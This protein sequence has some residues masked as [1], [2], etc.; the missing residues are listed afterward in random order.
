MPQGC[1]FGHKGPAAFTTQ[2]SIWLGLMQSRV[3]AAMLGLQLSAADAAARS[4]EVGI[5]QKTPVPDLRG[6]DADP[7][8]ELARDCVDIKRNLDTANETSHVF[9]RPALLA[10]SGKTLEERAEAWEAKVEEAEARLAANQREID[11]IAFRLYG[12]KGD[13][14]RAIEESL[15]LTPTDVASDA[16]TQE[17]E[18]GGDDE[19]EEG[20]EETRRDRRTLAAELISYAV[21]CAFGRFDI[22]LGAGLRTPDPLPD[23]FAPLPVC[24]PGMLTGPDG[25]P[26]APPAGYPPLAD[27]DG[28]LVEDADE[29]GLAYHQDDIVLRVR[30]ALIVLFG[31]TA[32]RIEVEA[33]RWLEI[34]SL[35]DYFKR[36]GAGGFWLDHVKRYSKSR[37]KAP[38]YWLLQSSRK[39]Y[40]LWLY[41]HKLDG[42][43][44]FKALLNYAEPA[45]KREHDAQSALRAQIET[46]PIGSKERREAERALERQEATVGEMTD[47]CEKLREAAERRL[48]PDLNDGVVLTIAPLHALVPWKEAAD[49]WKALLAG[50]YPWSSITRQLRDRGMAS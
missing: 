28:I 12:I 10:V 35:R 11:D 31:E 2:P 44:L 27:E 6:P 18:S 21:G 13:D 30:A 4:Y 8:G 45:L 14:R 48:V 24:S 39:S 3:F 26:C 22:R 34:P 50:K 1:I 9:Q 15:N 20:G 36:P 32:D 47:F 33:C 7:L 40:S 46:L 23:P 37:R 29:R 19:E 17:A 41:A 16:S 25:L 43:T 38:I 49:Y 5:I 42:D